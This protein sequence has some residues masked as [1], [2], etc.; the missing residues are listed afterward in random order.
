MNMEYKNLVKK[1]FMGIRNES[2]LHD[3]ILSLV[4]TLGFDGFDFI[5]CDFTGVEPIISTVPVEVATRYESER[6][7]EHDIIIDCFNNSSMP[8]FQS[9]LFQTLNN[10]PYSLSAQKQAENI[11]KLLSSVGIH[12]MYSIPI[13][14]VHSN[15]KKAA[16]TVYCNNMPANLLPKKVAK[17]K[18]ELHLVASMITSFQNRKPARFFRLEASKNLLTPRQIEVL[19]V[20]AKHAV[21]QKDAA[22]FLGI[23]PSTIEKH[24]KAAVLALGAVSV[25]NAIYIASTELDLL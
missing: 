8:V 10:M 1:K 18:N 23:A 13:D 12:N 3:R 16:F 6:L 24:C 11:G 21:S 4:E 15:Y 17:V 25:N 14:A 2:V 19:E 5:N 20:M 22:R 9:E 7:Y